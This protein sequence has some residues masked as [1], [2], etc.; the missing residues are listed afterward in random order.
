M[1]RIQ[2]MA[3]LL[4]FTVLFLLAADYQVPEDKALILLQSS[5]GAPVL[6]THKTHSQM[7]E[8]TCVKCH[9]SIA[10]EGEF[11]QCQVC[12][13]ERGIDISAKEAF[14][15]FCVK[16]HKDSKSPTAPVDCEK[17]HVEKDV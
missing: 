11:K 5:G 12:H 9:G 2:T 4:L 7:A 14:H 8:I 3:G 16:C 15:G 1:R 13:K 17:C 10:E 6:F